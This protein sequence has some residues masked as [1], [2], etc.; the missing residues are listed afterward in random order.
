MNSSHRAMLRRIQNQRAGFVGGIGAQQPMLPSGNPRE[1]V[2][3]QLA[4]DRAYLAAE[5]LKIMAETSRE[6][7][8]QNVA[9]E[10]VAAAAI[11]YPDLEEPEEAPATGAV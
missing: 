1:Y 7:A 8:L 9:R 4:N 2:E 10:C 11:I 6:M 3:E 5:L